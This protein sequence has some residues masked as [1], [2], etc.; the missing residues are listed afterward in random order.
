[1]KKMAF[2]IP[3]MRMGGAEK[4]ALNF[5]PYLRKHFDVTIVMNI[6]EGELL[7]A[8]PKD[9]RIIEDRLLSFDEVLKKDIKG[10]KLVSIYKDLLYYY[11]IKTGWHKEKNYRYIIGRTPALSEKFDIAISYV[12]NISTQIFSLHDRTNA[13]V[14]IAWIHGE[15]TE[16]HDTELFNSLYSDFNKICVVSNVSKEHFVKRFKDC[17]G[18]TEVYYNPINKEDIIKKSTEK[19]DIEFGEGYNI[20]SVGRLSPEKGFIMLPEIAHILKEKSIN[21]HWYLI[22]DGP[23][24]TEIE[25]KIKEFGVEEQVILLGNKINP[26]PYIKNCDVY[27]QP[28][29]EEGYSTTI[30]EAGILGRVI[31]GTTTSGGIREQITDGVSGILAEPTP[32]DLADKICEII[33]NK[34][35]CEKI[36]NNV[37]GLDFSNSGEEQ[38]IAGFCN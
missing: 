7:D 16:L 26:Y 37:K 3:A 1:M 23:T 6:I 21:F 18:I 13:D 9:I 11:R 2:I 33:G 32:V 4:I 8:L 15:T 30:C 38:K 35:L 17:E 25:E 28:S 19:T 14:K 31:I 34:E 10:F 36:S 5:I 20:V 27:V 22:G 24:R 12:A 29:Y